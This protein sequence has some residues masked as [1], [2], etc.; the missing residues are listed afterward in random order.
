M[1]DATPAAP[2]SSLMVAGVRL[3]HGLITAFFLTC[4]GL[5]F[6]AGITGEHERL[7]WGAALA[8]VAEGGV[9]ML[10]G[11]DCPLG[12]VHQRFGDGKA[13]FELLLP[14][15]LA[16]LA[17]PFFGAVAAAGIVLLIL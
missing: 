1:P 11:G 10:N 5:M 2:Y 16:K 4:L 12:R 13:F 8:V 17:V 3:V 9:V 7:A 15:R 14:P 6:Y